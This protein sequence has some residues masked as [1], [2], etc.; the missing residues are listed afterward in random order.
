[1]KYG[2][3]FASLILFSAIFYLFFAAAFSDD[4]WHSIRLSFI[5]FLLAHIA[6]LPLFSFGKRNFSFNSGN[7]IK[8]SLLP[9]KNYIGI[10]FGY[11]VWFWLHSDG[12]DNRN[13]IILGVFA[14]VFVVNLY[15]FLQ[16]NRK[17]CP[18]ITKA[19]KIFPTLVL[20]IILIGSYY[21][22][23]FSMETKPDLIP[24]PPSLFMLIL[25]GFAY[26]RKMIFS[27]ILIKRLPSNAKAKA[28]QNALVFIFIGLL[29]ASSAFKAPGLYLGVMYLFVLFGI[30]SQ[31]SRQRILKVITANKK[32]DS[33]FRN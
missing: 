21:S 28:I 3:I 15:D 11:I 4:F 30:T 20:L 10:G 32:T 8:D 23:K 31:F 33:V 29:I 24:T 27:I 19:K 14:A 1:M 5:I 25:L 9:I 22:I 18:T 26:F 16:A 6:N 12:I 13:G 2:P 17:S 7:W